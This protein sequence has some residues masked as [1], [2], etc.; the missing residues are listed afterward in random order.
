MNVLSSKPGH[1]VHIDDESFDKLAF[2]HDRRFRGVRFLCRL[3]GVPR[4]G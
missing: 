4:F 2:R 3:R 1:A